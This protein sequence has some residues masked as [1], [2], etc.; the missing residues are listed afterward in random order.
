MLCYNFTKITFHFDR[1][2]RAR[3]L[4]LSMRRMYVP[5]KYNMITRNI[6]DVRRNR[7]KMKKCNEWNLAIKIIIIV[8]IM[9]FFFL[10]YNAL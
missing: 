7:K 8:K 9:F 5:I 1:T 2:E 4:S 3:Y 6:H 10:K